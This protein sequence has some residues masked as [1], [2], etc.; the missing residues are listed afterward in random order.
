MDCP[1]DVLALEYTGYGQKYGK[2]WQRQRCGRFIAGIP[3]PSSGE[4]GT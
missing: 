3:V 2:R 1:H 4:A